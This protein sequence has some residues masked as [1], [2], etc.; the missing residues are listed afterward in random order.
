[1]CIISVIEGKDALNIKKKEYYS[2]NE[3]AS[4]LIIKNKQNKNKKPPADEIRE[5]RKC[6]SDS[7]WKVDRTHRSTLLNPPA[8]IL[9]RAYLCSPN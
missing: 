1:M 8:S 2:V 5:A 9:R 3:E 7:E 4:K 6:L